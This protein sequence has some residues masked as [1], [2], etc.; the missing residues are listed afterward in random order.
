MKTY[1]P[2]SVVL[3]DR[4][5]CFNIAAVLIM[6]SV[7]S[8]ATRILTA[9]P[10]TAPI[11]LKLIERY[12]MNVIKPLVGNLVACLKYLRTHKFDLS[13]VR[14]VRAS[15]GKL[16]LNY[17]GD[18]KHHFPNAKIVESYGLSELGSISNSTFFDPIV[19]P[20]DHDDG[21][22][23]FPNRIVKIVDENGARCGPNVLG[24][25]RIKVAHEFP[26]YYND[27]IETAN[28][29]DDEGFFRTGDMG[30]FNDNGF[31]LIGDRLK[32]IFRIYYYKATILPYEIEKTLAK[33]PNIKDVCV[34]GILINCQYLPAA[35]VV[36][37]PESQLSQHDVFN[38]VAGS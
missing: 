11:Q 24:E 32:D 37:M 14:Y 5:I 26:G 35:V 1:E 27:P 7:Y 31:L 4:V 21:H 2:D 20:G 3:D 29:V 36:R 8:G 18:I 34:V 10:L 23:L 12:K 38:M 15:S 16:F 6:V 19:S 9:E 30:Q 33:M 28:A 17:V 13:S 25:I 22:R